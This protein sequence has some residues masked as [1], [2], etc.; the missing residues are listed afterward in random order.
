MATGFDYDVIV[1]GAGAAGLTAAGI[2]ANLGAKTVMVE[3]HRLG[4]DCTWTGCVP[5]KTLL[6]SAKVAHTMRTADRYG[7][8][9][10]EPEIDFKRVMEHVRA[11]R[12]AV[13]EDADAPEIFEGMGVEVRLGTARFVDPHTVEVEGDGGREW[14]SG[15]YVVIATGARP[16]V[17][18]IDGLGEVDYL[19]SDTLFEL[20]AQ[21]RRLAIVGGGPIGTEMSQA[22]TWLGTRVTVLDRADRI[23]GKDDPEL[24]ALLQA[25]LE[26]D[27]VQYVFGAQI[28]R[29]A[30]AEG[31]GP[32]TLH[33]GRAGGE[34]LEV[35]ADAL[36]LATGRTANVETLNLEAAGVAYEGRGVTVD[37][38]GRTSQAHILAVGDATGRYQFTHMSGHTAKVAVTNALLKIPQTFDDAHVPWVTYTEPELAHV[39]ATAEELEEA[40]TTFTTYRFPYDRLDRALTEHETTGLVKVHATPLTGTILGASILGARAGDLICEVAVAMKHG[41]TLR[42]LAE[43]IHPYPAY[44]EAVKRVADQWYVQKQSATVTRLVQTVFGYRGPVNTFEEGQ[45]V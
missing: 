41:V 26:A 1:L 2:A 30:Q 35:E 23:L 33:V 24:A 27:G 7:L 31:G 16:F 4:G 34:G 28:D 22:F 18:P 3:R 9:P 40:G 19:T 17:P 12:R 36:L 43:T 29:V 44:A 6:K 21:P 11:T 8:G 15:R 13:Y 38:R 42:H 14:I 32:V 37:A 5:S 45:I 39:G 20:D 25:E 10:C